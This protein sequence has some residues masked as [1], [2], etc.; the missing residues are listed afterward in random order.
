VQQPGRLGRV[1]PLVGRGH[2]GAGGL[3]AGEKPAVG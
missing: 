3:Q 1:E 2:G